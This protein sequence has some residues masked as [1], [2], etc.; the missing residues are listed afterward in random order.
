MKKLTYVLGFLF[1]AG[2]GMTTYATTAMVDNNTK[3]TIVDQNNDEKPCKEGCTCAKC[4]TPKSAKADGK[5][6]KA[7][8]DKSAKAACGEKAAAKSCCGSKSAA[9]TD[10]KKEAAPTK[11]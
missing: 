1:V 11:K 7:D 2:M 5:T 6:A 8:C 4:E 3:I 10:G 9:K